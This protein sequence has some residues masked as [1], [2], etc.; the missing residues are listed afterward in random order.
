[1]ILPGKNSSFWLGDKMAT[2][3]L[4]TAIAMASLMGLQADAQEEKPNVIY[5]LCDDLGYAQR[6]EC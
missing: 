3:I 4:S 1:M 5:I 6:T 2:R